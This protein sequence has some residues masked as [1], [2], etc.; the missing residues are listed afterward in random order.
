M[1]LGNKKKVI[2]K[3]ERELKESI[4]D[5]FEIRARI[6][7]DK[8]DLFDELSK[9]TFLEIAERNEGLIVINV[10][11]RDIRKKPYLF[12][13][14]YFDRDKIKVL[15]S[16]VAGMSPKKRRLDIL[17][18]FLNVL[19]LVGDTYVV[20]EKEI[21]QLLQ[22]AIKDMSEYVTLDYERMYA[23]HDSLKNEVQTLKKQTATLRESN[24]L[25]SRENYG[26]KTRLEE[27]KLKLEKYESVSD[28]VLAV[29]L[30]EWISEHSGEIDI[31]EFSRVYEVPE[32]RIEEMLNKLVM[33][34][35]LESR[36]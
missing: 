16:C 14:T 8:K 24:E 36:D 34:G 32:S 9:L 2:G 17:S 11:S 29:R 3:E 5:G 12:S 1:I 21:Y 18:Y 25:L 33:K 7:G 10:E 35:F 27:Y 26:L 20:D 22:N 15:Y 23:E 19:T 4:V 31:T 28:E 6:K 13:V 30:Q